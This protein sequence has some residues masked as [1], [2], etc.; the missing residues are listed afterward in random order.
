MPTAIPG[1][2]TCRVTR[3]GWGPTRN[4]WR[5]SA[6]TRCRST[7]RWSSMAST[8]VP[9]RRRS[10]RPRRW[11]PM[12]GARNA[13]T[14]SLRTGPRS[15]QAICPRTR[16]ARGRGH[17]PA[18]RPRQHDRRARHFG[19][20]AHL[21]RPGAE[22]R[23]RHRSLRHAAGARAGP[24]RLARR[25]RGHGRLAHL[26]R[27]RGRR[28]RTGRGRAHLGC[29]ADRRRGL[30]PAFL[31]PRRPAR[32]RPLGRSRRGA[33]GDAQAHGQ[34]HSV[35]HAP[36]PRTP[37]RDASRRPSSSAPSPSCARPARARCSWPRSMRPGVTP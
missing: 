1:A 34:P 9:R 6:R 23:P 21:R 27:R 24:G 5:P 18:Q 31:L 19:P 16:A 20:A 8:S 36:S 13:P 37:R 7:C 35:G 22:S 17:R 3:V 11:R 26:L 14:S 30:G 4:C 12:R 32:G 10:R 29:A 2:S 28:P 15:N 25:G 33:L